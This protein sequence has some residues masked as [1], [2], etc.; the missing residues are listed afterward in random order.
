MHAFVVLQAS[1]SG[2]QSQWDG[3]GVR[4][5][6]LFER[7]GPWILAAAV[8]ALVVHALLRARQFRVDAVLAKEA[9]DRVHA[10][11]VDVERRTV[12][13]IVP[14]VLGR[15]DAHPS[16]EWRS[17]LALLVLG[18][19]LLE[20]VLPWHSPWLVILFQ[21]VLGA[22]GFGLARALP[23]WKRVFVTQA[24]ATEVAL[25]QASLE[26]QRLELHRTAGRTGV[27][28]FVSLFERRVVVL[29]DAGIHAKVG[30]AQW[31]RTRDAVLAGIRRHDLAAG[32]V[33]G[34]RECGEVLALHFPVGANDHNEIPDRLVVRDE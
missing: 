13:E 25:E 2:A 34:V 3:L 32:L 8:L 23:G 15:S 24:R 26:F 27:L 18:S 31:A 1:Q 20:G 11:L 4:A 30:D 22:I 16:G 19:A 10:E 17:G 12:G 21:V 9:Q 6:D 29:G 7:A 28:I 14:V 33:D 5:I